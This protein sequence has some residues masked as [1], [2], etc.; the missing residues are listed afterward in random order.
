MIT[1][2]HLDRTLA[3]FCKK[4]HIKLTLDSYHGHRLMYGGTPV[5]GNERFTT[6]ELYNMLWFYMDMNYALSRDNLES[7][8]HKRN[9]ILSSKNKI[10]ALRD[11]R[12]QYG[13][14][15]KEAISMYN[16]IITHYNLDVP[17]ITIFDQ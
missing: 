5:I 12:A 3:I 13:I 8:E 9:I 10:N 6:K 16:E 4:Y 14:G 17:L 11:L 7:N 2:K 1:K 15:L